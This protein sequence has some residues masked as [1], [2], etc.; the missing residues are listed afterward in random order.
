MLSK[1]NFYLIIVMN[2]IYNVSMS[3]QII[4]I[5]NKKINID[6]EG[7]TTINIEV[8]ITDSIQEVKIGEKDQVI[9]KENVKKDEK[10]SYRDT[11]PRVAISIG[12]NLDFVGKIKLR[13]IYADI[14]ICYNQLFEKSKDKRLQRLGLNFGL[15]NFTTVSNP[16]TSKVTFFSTYPIFSDSS[17]VKPGFLLSK[18]NIQTK[19]YSENLGAFFEPKINIFS[20]E[21][22]TNKINL[23][24]HIGWS[25]N[26]YKLTNQYTL[27]GIDTITKVTQ[28]ITSLPR[29][30]ETSVSSN[31]FKFIENNV[32]YGVGCEFILESDKAYVQLKGL[33]GIN[34]IKYLNYIPEGSKISNFKSNKWVNFSIEVMEKR[35]TGIKIGAELR[36]VLDANVELPIQKQMPSYNIYM[37]KQFNLDKIAELFK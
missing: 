32:T 25:R 19:N 8:K 3:G 17:S 7:D 21:E 33:Y 23:I 10:V 28:E 16:D 37:A 12:T 9:K 24:G 27:I 36:A 15:Y 29:F 34:H 13:D 18:Y 6:L 26:V 11:L 31:E 30:N 1:T 35:F 20:K 22:G 4:N 2:L 14:K 5:D